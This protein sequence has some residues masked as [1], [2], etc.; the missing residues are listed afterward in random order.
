MR[1]FGFVCFWILCFIFFDVVVCRHLLHLG[2]PSDFSNFHDKRPPRV[3]V[4]Y[5]SEFLVK[6]TSFDK[7]V[8]WKEKGDDVIRVAFFGGS[9]GLPVATKLF[10]KRLSKLLGEKVEVANF[11]ICSGNH[12]QHLH[13]ILEILHHSTP[14]IIVFYGGYNETITQGRFDPRPGYPYSY[15]YRG[16]L[17]TVKKFLIENSALFGAYEWRYNTI[18]HLSKLREEYKPFSEE[19]NKTIVDKYFSNMEL[20]KRVSE[21]LPSKK[22]GNTKFI[23]FYQ[24]YRAELIPEFYPYH[25]NIRERIKNVDYI[26]DIHDYYDQF[27]K[28]IYIDECHVDLQITNMLVVKLSDEIAKRF[29]K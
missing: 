4:E 14:D 20:A 12:T 26:I 16:E 27:G 1:K 21:S 28:E 13:T 17:S 2:H 15:Y 22:Y 8:F 25:E 11:S 23:A 6:E 9:T 29:S 5:T 7:T 10:S 24:P 3:Y 18:T 19:W